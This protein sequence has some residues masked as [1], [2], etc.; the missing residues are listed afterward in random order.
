MKKTKILA[1]GWEQSWWP[2]VYGRQLIK[3]SEIANMVFAEY[4]ST[5]LEEIAKA[6]FKHND[7][8]EFIIFNRGFVNV[9]Q[10]NVKL[11][12][13]FFEMYSKFMDASIGIIQN[14]EDEVKKITNGISHYVEFQNMNHIKDMIEAKIK[15]TI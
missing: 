10:K 13:D 11:I 8:I 1:V 12:I 3:L 15:E 5:A 7:P 2:D 9:Q 4:N 14:N 6:Q